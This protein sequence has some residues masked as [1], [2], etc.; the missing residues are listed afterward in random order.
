MSQPRRPRKTRSRSSHAKESREES[1]FGIRYL[2]HHMFTGDTESEKQI[3][4]YDCQCATSMSSLYSGRTLVLL[5][6]S[7]L[8]LLIGVTFMLVGYL[9][10]RRPVVYLEK[11]DGSRT[12]V[13]HSAIKFNNLLDDFT[14]VGT[15]LVPLGA[16]IFCIIL[17]FPVC[18][19]SPSNRKGQYIKAPTEDSVMPKNKT[20]DSG[21]SIAS[22][23]SR[24]LSSSVSSASTLQ[25]IPVLALVHNVQPEKKPD[26]LGKGGEFKMKTGKWKDSFEDPDE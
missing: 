3:C 2:H 26:S 16:V 17:I 14:L 20:L 6:V 1:R 25:K 7:M 22:E 10:P 13:D 24:S 9:I 18:R 11:S 23:E 19:S 15:A 21:A 8:I 5:T 4:P 12:L